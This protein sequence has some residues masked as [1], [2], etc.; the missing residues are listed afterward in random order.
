MELRQL[1]S[2]VTL[3]E[4][5]HSGRAAAREYIVQSAL[6]Q[7][8][9]WSPRDDACTASPLPASPRSAGPPG[10]RS[11]N[12]PPATRG[13]CCGAPSTPPATCRPSSAAHKP[14]PESAGRSAVD[15]SAKIMS[16]L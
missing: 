7:P 8:P 13:Q 11:P 15:A 12:Q 9:T 6:S 14:Y 3:A 10:G 1:R 5:L 2:F 16:T 4:E